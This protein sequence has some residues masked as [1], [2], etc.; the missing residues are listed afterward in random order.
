MLSVVLAAVLV[1]ACGAAGAV[2]AGAADIPAGYT[3]I[4]TA[5]QLNNVRSNLGGKYILMNNIDVASLGYWGPIGGGSSPFTGI[6]DGGGYRIT[7][8]EIDLVSYS[9]TQY[10][11][12]AGLF[13]QIR[14]GQVKKLG[15]FSE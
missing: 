8:M 10:A 11:I 6:L 7:G 14:G 4:Y 1:F 9:Q 5:A 3:A 13:G 2:P 15:V 12:Y